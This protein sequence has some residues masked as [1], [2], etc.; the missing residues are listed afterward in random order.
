MM[1]TTGFARFA[2]LKQEAQHI[3]LIAD[4]KF[5]VFKTKKTKKRTKRN[6]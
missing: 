4:A 1:L 3:T 6:N 2:G 5:A